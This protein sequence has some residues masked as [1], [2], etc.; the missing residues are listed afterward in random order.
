MIHT[1]PIAMSVPNGPRTYLEPQAEPSGQ[2]KVIEYT[3]VVPGAVLVIVQ[4]TSAK[5][6]PA[7]KKTAA[8]PKVFDSG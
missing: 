5:T 7:K 3:S 1:A 8:S 6:T 2:V 4:V